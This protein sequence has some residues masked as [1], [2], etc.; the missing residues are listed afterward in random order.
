MPDRGVA[1]DDRHTELLGRPSDAV[2]HLSACCAVR[3][4]QHVDERQRPPAH[5]AHVGDVGD[6]GGGAGAER[7]G[8][9]E[10]RRHRL[11]ADHELLA[12]VRHER[13]VVAVD[14]GGEPLDQPHGALALEAG[15]GADRLGELLELVHRR[16]ST[17]RRSAAMSD[18]LQGVGAI[19]VGLSTFADA[20]RAQGAPVVEVDWRPPAGGD[21]GRSS[22]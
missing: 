14:A 12:A 16:H 10:R 13:R 8:L 11:A 4:H 15:R 20:L 5:G 3:A 6:H 21:A 18:V 2:E 17:N 1:A 7:V 22:C 19:N 9:H